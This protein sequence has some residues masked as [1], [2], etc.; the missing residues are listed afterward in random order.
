MIP[1]L[2]ERYVTMCISSGPHYAFAIVFSLIFV[3]ARSSGKQVGTEQVALINLL[4]NR[5]LTATICTEWHSV[6]ALHVC[7]FNEV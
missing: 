7:Y 4:D 5:Y 6:Y 2:N 1:H 3:N